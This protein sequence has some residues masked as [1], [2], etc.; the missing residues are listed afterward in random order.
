M[1]PPDHEPLPAAAKDDGISGRMWSEVDDLTRLLDETQRVLQAMRE[2]TESLRRRADRDGHAAGLAKAQAEAVRHVLDAHQV[3]RSGVYESRIID[4]A[5]S[6]VARIA[7]T[8]SAPDAVAGL[9]A[10]AVRAARKERHLRIH[11]GS[12]AAEA[13]REMV[14]KWQETHPEIAAPQVLAEPQLSPFACV[15]ESELGSVK[16][17]P[18]ETGA[19]SSPGNDTFF[20]LPPDGDR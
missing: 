2:Q 15:V 1:V 19:Q 16:V 20:W 17:D 6:I 3:A 7:P 11:V 14:R 9:A 13:T 10:E 4:L 5:V 18:V 12:G 8:L